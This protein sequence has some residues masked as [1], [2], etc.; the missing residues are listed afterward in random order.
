MKNWKRRRRIQVARTTSRMK[1]RICRKHLESIEMHNKS[2]R[3]LR[4]FV[5]VI[6]ILAMAH[7]SQAQSTP[8]RWHK[9]F[10]LNRNL[11][12]G[13]GI[14]DF[15][16]KDSLYGLCLTTSGSI[17]STSDGGRHW[18]LDTTLGNFSGEKST[19]NSLECTAPHQG[20][21]HGVAYSVSIAPSRTRAIRAYNVPV[22]DSL[23]VNLG[24][25]LTLAEKM[26]DTLYGFRLVEYVNWYDPTDFWDTVAIIVT[27]DGW[28]SSAIYGLPYLLSPT[29]HQRQ[30]MRI[31]YI[32]DSNDVWT[33]KGWSL[34]SNVVLHTSN[35]G[36]VWNEL[37]PS[38]TVIGY[39][40]VFVDISVRPKTGE[41]FCLGTY[42]GVDFAYT[43][44]LGNTWMLNSSF[45]KNIGANAAWRIANPAT[46]ILWALIGQGQNH[47]LQ[48]S[49]DNGLTWAIDSTTYMSD[50]I[51]EMH[52]M[53]ARH[54]WIASWSHD[55]LFMWYYDA[56][57]K[58]DVAESPAPSSDLMFVL[59]NPAQ[60]SITVS[61]AGKVLEIFDALGRS[62]E[63]PRNGSTLDISR[64]PAG[65]YYVS[66]GTHRARF[67]K[68]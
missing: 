36:A 21:F 22:F 9:I 45:R 49:S 50:T 23:E 30:L 55:S 12:E 37:H 34:N 53:D 10:V 5:R 66:D 54:G 14:L 40:P 24:A 28:Q 46:G 26:Y 29:P 64:L 39:Q 3:F 32:V 17:L 11:P 16:F 4:H 63:C 18:A 43:S 13:E 44:D 31:G 48:Y 57:A 25:Y 47:V 52:F 62:R 67:V 15:D 6:A 61:G 41:V 38:D 58:S 27:H 56:D 1:A 42:S 19:L 51:Q 7:A 65:V 8:G 60:T 59:P 35:G 20:F 2:L 33:A 68:E